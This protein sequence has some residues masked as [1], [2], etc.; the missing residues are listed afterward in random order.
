M[1]R[2]LFS[3]LGLKQHSSPEYMQ[4]LTEIM[5]SITDDE[6][7][8]RGLDSSEKAVEAWAQAEQAAR[9]AQRDASNSP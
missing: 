7:V 8:L 6:K 1:G 5:R 9:E 3:G 4:S 2:A